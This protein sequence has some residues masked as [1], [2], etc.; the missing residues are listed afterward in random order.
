MAL[1]ISYKYKMERFKKIGKVM[2]KK[3]IQIGKSKI[4]IGF[5]K[6][7]R[8]IFEPEKAYPFMAE[9]G[10]KWVR[11]QSGWQKTEQQKGV[12]NFE[13]LDKIVDKMIEMGIEPW[14]CLCYGNE[15]Y[16]QAAKAVFGAV[17]CPPIKTE[18]E[19]VAWKKYVEATVTHFK[20]RVHYYEVWNEPDGLWCWKHGPNAE[21]LADFIIATAKACKNAD[22]NCKVIGL[23]TCEAQPEFHNTLFEKGIGDYIDAVSYHAYR[24]NDDEF[25]QFNRF[26]YDLCKKYNPDL[27]LIQGESGFQSDPRGK[28]ALCGGNWTPEKQAKGLLRHLIT[29]IAHDVEFTSY[30]SCMDMAE[31]LKGTV[32]DVASISDFGYFGVVGAEFDENACATEDYYAK[33]AFYALQTLCAILCEEYEKN[34]ISIENIN[35]WSY[36][37]VGWGFNLNKATKYFFK[38]PDNSA[39]LIYWNPKEITTETYDGETSF[40]IKRDNLSDNVKLIDMLDGSIYELDYEHFSADED[41]F[42]FHRMPLTDSPL[43]ISFGNFV[44]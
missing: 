21:E 26:Y 4:G 24:V 13:W 11:L 23:A 6:L 41:Y 7:D 2:P 8:D 5:E 32:G 36:K 20:G 37:R 43:L 10:V 18:E 14:L 42:Y 39:A 33:S 15:L 35:E 19:R 3:S 40:K 31:A 44:L 29:D 27:E 30:F 1:T 9:T 22:E 17:G 25:I 28:G 38:R 34:D 12:Y 16:T